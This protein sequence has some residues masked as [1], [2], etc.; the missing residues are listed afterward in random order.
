VIVIGGA[1]RTCAVGIVIATSVLL[2]GCVSTVSGTAMRAQHA[3][4]IEVPPLTEAKLDDVLLSVGEL[5]AIMGSRQMQV[6]SELQEMTDHSGEVSDPDCLGAIYGAEDPV[7]AGS[8]W[9]AMR[10]QVVREPSESNEHWVEQ[11]AVLYPVP[12][13][14]R[15]FFD[16]S[17]SSWRKCSGYSVSVDDADATYLWQI[18][19][20]ISEDTLITQMTAQEDADG[21]ACQHALS[22][23]S[24]LTVEAWACGYSIKDEAA[25]IATDMIGN[26]AK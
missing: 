12:E 6:T 23:A 15:A 21:W 16:D 22:V 2:S 14:A 25:T 24:N 18:D 17:K 4:P 20:V 13:K 26:A 1:A 7:Y 3:G 10:D 5:N 11:T 8:G 19:N 9:T